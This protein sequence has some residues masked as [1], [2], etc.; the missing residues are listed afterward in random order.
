MGGLVKNEYEKAHVAELVDFFIEERENLGLE[1]KP[2]TAYTHEKAIGEFRK[3]IE[4]TEH[5]KKAKMMMK[6]RGEPPPKVIPC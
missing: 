4:D 6:Y 2:P 3:L 1:G 5:A